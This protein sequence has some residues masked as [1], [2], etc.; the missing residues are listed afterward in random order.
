RSRLVDFLHDAGFNGIAAK[1][2]NDRNAAGDGLHLARRGVAATDDDDRGREPNKFV[3]E[4]RGPCRITVGV[5]I[6][7][8]DVLYID[9]TGLAQTYAPC[10]DK[11]RVAIHRSAIEETNHGHGALL[12]ATNQRPA[13]STSDKGDEPAPPH[14]PP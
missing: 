14:D 8:G 3:D 9:E 6:L 2:R 5:T 10:F 11:R 12:D 7:N 1:G 4:P 13:S